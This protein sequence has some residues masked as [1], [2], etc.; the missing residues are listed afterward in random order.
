MAAFFV[1]WLSIMATFVD[2]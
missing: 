2:T 1:A